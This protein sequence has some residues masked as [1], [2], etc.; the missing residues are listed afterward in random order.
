MIE[1]RSYRRVFD[2]ERRLYSVDRLRLNPGGVPVRGVV[3]FLAIL[4]GD[5]LAGS[6]PGARSLVCVLPWYL[7]DIGLPVALATVF[8]AIRLEG[9]TFHLAAHGLVRYWLGPRRLAGGRGCRAVGALWHP[10]ESRDLRRVRPPSASDALHRTGG[11][12][13]VRRARAP[14]SRRRAGNDGRG[15]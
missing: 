10:P 9:R 3:Y 5:L 11:R 1:I 13:G 12:A 2:L 7:R 15:S 8:S 6:V 4:A 14:R